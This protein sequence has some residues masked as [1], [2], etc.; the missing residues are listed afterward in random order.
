MEGT[1][2]KKNWVQLFSFVVIALLTAEDGVLMLQNGELRARLSPRTIGRIAPLQPGEV[3]RPIMVKTLDGETEELKYVDTSKRHLI[4][5]F[6]TTCP[7]CVKNLPAWQML[8]DSIERDKC[9]IIGI[10]A[11]GLD[12]TRKFVTTKEL[13]FVT[14]SAAD[15]TS[16]DRKYG[17]SGYPLTILISGDAKVEKT[18]IGELTA[19]QTNEIRALISAEKPSSNQTPKANLRF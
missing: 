18:W 8:A 11:H 13:S 4:F 2:G 14:V 15:D 3:I 5:V 12:E 16:F 6:S 9:D 19:Q 7:H 10:S 17:I 1:K